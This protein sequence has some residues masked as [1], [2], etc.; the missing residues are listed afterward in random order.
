[1]LDDER[2][3]R[4]VKWN[5]QNRKVKKEVSVLVCWV[6]GRY[7]RVDGDSVCPRH[8]HVPASPHGVAT[9]ETNINIISTV[10]ISDLTREKWMN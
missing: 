2:P 8:R 5:R 6:V 1:V 4:A 3:R 7:Q 9:Q 10:R